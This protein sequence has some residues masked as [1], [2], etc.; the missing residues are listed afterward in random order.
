[1]TVSRSLTSSIRLAPT[2]SRAAPEASSASDQA[3]P[4]MSPARARRIQ[5]TAR[6][7]GVAAMARMT[8][9]VCSATRRSAADSV[10]R[11]TKPRV[12]AGP[13]KHSSMLI[14]AASAWSSDRKP[15]AGEISASIRVR[16]PSMT[17]SPFSVSPISTE[18]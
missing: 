1:M 9:E 10:R 5:R 13:S 18:A 8:S 15:T 16:M 12:S 3:S 6:T 11:S 7:P 14:P 4:V 2:S 17:A